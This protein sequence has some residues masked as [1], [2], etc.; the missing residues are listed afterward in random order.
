MVTK[1]APLPPV[2]GDE[3]EQVTG[4]GLDMF[5]D[6]LESLPPEGQVKVSLKRTP[7]DLH[8]GLTM[9]ASLFPPP[10][11]GAFPDMQEEVARRFGPGEYSITVLWY[12][13]GGRKDRRISRPQPFRIESGDGGDR[14]LIPSDLGPEREPRRISR[15]PSRGCLPSG[16]TRPSWT[17]RRVSP[18]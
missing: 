5:E 9:P 17:R 6:F 1:K 11:I 3:L 2:P 18:A 4:P 8:P 13:P 7:S 15:P 12:G 14:E 10:R 16:R